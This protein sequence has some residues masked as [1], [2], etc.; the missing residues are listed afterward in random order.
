MTATLDLDEPRLDPLCKLL[1]GEQRLP[2][3]QIVLFRGLPG[4]GKTNLALQLMVPYA[5]QDKALYYSL[6]E[7]SA[8]LRS[9]FMSLGG[10]SDQWKR[11]YSDLIPEGMT[12]FDILLI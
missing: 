11:V 5:Q 6:E 10:S 3:G 2:Y 12:L 7:S 9:R 4:T 8:T 1:H